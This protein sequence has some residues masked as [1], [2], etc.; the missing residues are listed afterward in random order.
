MKTLY[1]RQINSFN[2]CFMHSHQISTKFTVFES[3]EELSDSE[4]ELLQKAIEVRDHAYA[5]Y[6]DFKVGASVL[7][8]T[9]EVFL[10]N[11]QENAAYPSGICAERVA[12]W[13]AMSSLPNGKIKKIFISARSGKTMVNRPVA[14]C[15]ACRQAIAEYETKQLSNI[16]IFF[17][18]EIGKIV[19]ANSIKDLLPWMFDNSMLT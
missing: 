6:S 16:E 12:I 3:A 7:M 14:P 18:G 1:L 13:T 11:N 17:T 19:K 10:G 5:P 15:G 4:K 2:C 9:N 8:E